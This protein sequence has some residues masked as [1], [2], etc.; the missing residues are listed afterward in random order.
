MLLLLLGINNVVKEPNFPKD[1]RLLIKDSLRV[2]EDTFSVFNLLPILPDGMSYE[3]FKYLQLRIDYW[4]RAWS[5]VLPGYI[6][7]ITYDRTGGMITALVRTVGFA[8]MGYVMYFG[9]PKAFEDLDPNT[10]RINAALFG[11]GMFLNFAGWVYDVVHGEYR[12]R[13]I[14]MRVLYKYRRTYPYRRE[15]DR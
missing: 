7:F 2:V 9:A 8:L 15:P 13:D 14:Q 5:T 1:V 11:A 12:L 3:E 4:D 10:L 6:H